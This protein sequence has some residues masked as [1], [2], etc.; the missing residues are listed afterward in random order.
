M[1][2]LKATMPEFQSDGR[3]GLPVGVGGPSAERHA[4][5]VALLGDGSAW[6]VR[7][8]TRWR[9]TRGLS[10]AGTSSPKGVGLIFKR[11]RANTK[12]TAGGS[13]GKMVA[14]T[15]SPGHV[16]ASS[17]NRRVAYV[18]TNYPQLFATFIADE[19]QAL[20]AR[21][22]QVF[23]VAMNSPTPSDVAGVYEK[24]ERDRTYY[25][26]RQT[27]WR[28]LVALSR[29]LL[30]S[31]LGLARTIALGVRTA[32]FDLKAVLWRIFHVGEAILVWNHCRRIDVHHIHAHFGLAP[33]TIAWFACTFGNLAGGRWTWSFTIHGFQDFVNER[34]AALASK[35]QSALYVVCVSD[36]TRSQIMRVSHSLYWDKF[37]VVRCGIA[38]DRF[39]FS[40]SHCLSE[41][42]TVLL[43]GRLSPEKGHGVL[44]DAL[45]LLRRDGI[46]AIVEFA[47]DGP[48]RSDLEAQAA[49][50]GVSERVRFLGGLHPSEVAE[51]L[52]RAD[53][54][55][56]P[57]FSEGL[58][59]SIMEAMAIGTPVVTT[60]I[61][62][63]P[64]LAVDGE[65]A[66]VVPAGNA[67]CL[68]AA[69]ARL[70]RDNDLRLRI[71][72]QARR[73][74]ELQHSLPENV[75]KL[76]ALLGSAMDPCASHVSEPPQIGSQH[77][78]PR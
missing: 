52:Q 58:P 12:S 34:D 23:P 63:I 47:G 75:R 20:E 3:F 14:N 31:P 74:V 78:S 28:V 25:L 15:Q 35:A 56:L 57:S 46:E 19:I 2:C 4:R 24:G 59:V 22:F 55:C 69:L 66:L 65:T 45:S 43:V 7:P 32:G 38:L 44:L 9:Q 11:R 64:E 33:A 29:A 39:T 41:R 60:H 16:S 30:A 62:G 1:R 73:R 71:V 70:L 8:P 61:G 68:A 42:P 48:I 27:P 6:P 50:L 77:A 76:E 72:H 5:S 37:H 17:V 10:A 40:P 67:S 36:F 51:R 26:K 54:F 18:M 13:R 53:V 49:R 21:G